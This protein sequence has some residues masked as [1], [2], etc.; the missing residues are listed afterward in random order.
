MEEKNR[1]IER[2][3]EP[4]NLESPHSV[5]DSFLTPDDLFY[6]R[7][8]FALPELDV[9][10]W[11]LRVEG[12]VTRV[13]EFVYG[14]LMELP[15]R[16]VVA[17][18][19]CAGNGRTFL[20]QKSKGVQW[21]MG[22]VGTAEW[23]G[24]PLHTVLAEVGLEEEAIEI[25][26]EGADSGIEEDP[27]SPGRIH[28]ARS[29][30]LSKALNSDVLLAYRMNGRELSRAHGFPVRALVPGWY[31]M[32]SVKWLQQI[33]IS[34]VPFAG[35]FQTIEYSRW[36]AVD[37]RPSLLPLSGGE[38]K[39]LITKPQDDETV[40]TGV[41]CRIC[42]AAWAGESEVAKVEVSVDG[43]EHWRPAQLLDPPRRYCWVRWECLW[44]PAQ[45]GPATLMARATDESGR[46]QPFK[47]PKENRHYAIHHVLPVSVRVE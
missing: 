2:Q 27:Q 19:E 30:P 6:V 21:E 26:L 46:S 8:H 45:S 31:G 44:T 41:N 9:T 23:T 16:T 33:F 4:E 7:N 10:G 38:V 36:K 29:L 40:K 22:A 13:R 17:T 39:A 14:E 32:A 5:F 11:R 28:Y 43:G 47:H 20:P 18:L 1:L 15:S 12:A 37:G 42:G 34:G 3:R 24:V 25:I 35:Y